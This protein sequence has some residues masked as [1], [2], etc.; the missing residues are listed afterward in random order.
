MNIASFVRDG[1]EGYGLVR[2]GGIID[3]S[4]R[5]GP[6]FPTLK[7]VL[8]H[9]GISMF[10]PVAQDEPDFQ[11][12][13]VMLLPPIPNPEKTICVGVNYRD[14][15][16]ETG[17]SQPEHPLLFLRLPNGQVGH[18]HP[19]IRPKI[20]DRFDFEG[21]LAVIIGRGGRYIAPENA[22]KH[23]AGYSCFNDGSI[24]DW[25]RH[26]S[27]FTPG[28]NFPQTAAFGPWMVTPD[29]VGNLSDISIQTRLNGDLMQASTLSQLIFDVP[30]LIAYCSSFTELSPGDVIVTGTPGGVGAF[31]SPPV[32]MKPGDTVEVEIGGIGTLRNQV[33]DES[34]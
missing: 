7:S 25:Q 11:L 22:M 18:G 30:A 10:E 9:G 6:L 20:S 17:R 8:E 29:D 19:L 26:T 15:L 32:W 1:S 13:K 21:E 28:K 2:N 34:V 16:E 23:I 33:I 27:Q 3:C 4:A 5:F 31:R 12:D 14:H 24:R